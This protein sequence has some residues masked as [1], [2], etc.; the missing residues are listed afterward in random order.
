VIAHPSHEQALVERLRKLSDDLVARSQR[1]KLGSEGPTERIDVL[2]SRSELMEAAQLLE[3]KRE[4]LSPAEY[5]AVRA[6]LRGILAE[7]AAG[8]KVE[9]ETIAD[10]VNAI[11]KLPYGRS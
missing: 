1:L 3:H 4:I 11:K 7:M 9:A 10:L 8:T 6:G 2:M 5:K